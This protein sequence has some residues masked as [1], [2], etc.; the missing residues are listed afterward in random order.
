MIIKNIKNIGRA[1]RLLFNA[2]N[3]I[4]K[5]L[6]EAFTLIKKAKK[7]ENS[8][9]GEFE[10]L[11][12][13]MN[14]LKID[15]GYIVD[16]AAGDGYRQSCTLDFF[17]KNWQ[18]LCVEMDPIRFSLLSFLY[19]QFPK[20]NLSKN[21]VTPLNVHLILKANDVPK[22]FDLLN[23]DIDSYDLE[24]M[25]KILEEN[26][27]PKVISMEINEKIPPPIY[28]STK[29]NKDDNWEKQ[30]HF[31]GCSITAAAD[32]LT[33]NGYIV[34]SLQYN[35]LVCLKRDLLNETNNK[36]IK[37]I[38][39]EGYKNKTDR[40]K[41]FPWNKNVDCLLNMQNNEVVNFLNK[42]FYEYKDKYT[43]YIKKN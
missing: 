6:L 36:D 33:K 14:K 32:L 35:N 25:G 4:T 27:M 12:K 3:Q 22:N 8:Y 16:I 2:N 39:D 7:K 29:F 30:D 38:Y 26:Y 31:F 1:I 24:V 10:Y 5:I 18:G 41:L 9:A 19:H 28:F 17:K 43:M 40:T 13:I 11:D 20:V 23:L 37:T 34:E 21:I 42:H 15:K